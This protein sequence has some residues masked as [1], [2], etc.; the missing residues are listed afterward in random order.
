[1]ALKLKIDQSELPDLKKFADEW[2]LYFSENN[3]RYHLFNKFLFKSTLTQDEVNNL[4]DLQVPV[5]EFNML[6]TYVSRLL[7]EFVKQEPASEIESGHDYP[8]PVDVTTIQT[9]DGFVRNTWDEAKR[10]GQTSHAYKNVLAGGFSV[11]EVF[12]EYAHAKT[13]KQIFKIR[14]VFDPTLCGFDPLAQEATKGDGRYCFRIFPRL[15]EEVEAAYPNADLKSI[16][17]RGSLMS[18]GGYTWAYYNQKN[19]K[20]L[21]VCEMFRKKKVPI[22]IHRLSNNME[23]TDKQYKTMMS[24]HEEKKLSIAPKII[25]SRDSEDTIICRYIFMDNQILEYEETDYST[26]PIVFVDGNSEVIRDSET[27]PAQQMTRPY[28]YNARDTQRLKN[29]AGQALANAIENEAQHK[30]SA[31]EEGIP[32]QYKEAYEDVQHANILVFKA[33]A[34]KDPNR[35]LP[36]P[37]V[38]PK[39]PAPPEIANTFTVAD[40]MTQ[41]ILGNFDL[42]IGKLNDTQLSGLAIQETITQSN[43][44]AMPSLNGYLLAYQHI[45]QFIIDMIP[46]YIVTPRTVPIVDAQGKRNFVKVNDDK[47]PRSIDLDYGENA[48]QIHVEAGMSFSMQKSRTLTQIFAAMQASPLFAQFMNQKGLR[49]L[50]DNFQE[51]NG[52]DELK[53][54]ANEFMKEMQ[55]QQQMQMQMQMLQMKQLANQGPNPA[56]VKAQTDQQKLQ[57]EQQKFIAD[58]QQIQT[59]NQFR[60]AEIA[61]DAQE[62]NNDKAKVLLQAQEQSNNNA[63]QVTKAHAEVF[64]KAVD[65]A[66]KHEDQQHSH[67]HDAVELAHKITMDH[68]NL[69]QQKKEATQSARTTE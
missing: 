67:A 23:L 43:A 29:R 19:E 49:I 61:N 56:I 40:S 57:L 21:L 62:N 1:M 9:V 16:N 34:D 31:A 47:D 25:E 11:L 36:R 38:I 4:I 15:L 42:S 48:L 24:I 51:I 64:S 2:Q 3:K 54:L 52:I 55:M 22:Q 65:F 63:V 5:L 35:P 6:E 28:F 20:I 58:Q 12:T 32:A 68:A 26:F 8:L 14:R 53:V 59:E 44:T 18:L 39:V 30:F 27:G 45:S 37:E 50:I 33:Y 60:A 66:L 7:G 10:T 46:K 41:N 69:A 17:F 13:F